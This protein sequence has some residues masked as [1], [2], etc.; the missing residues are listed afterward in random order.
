MAR[1]SP[2][3]KLPPEL[4]NHIY[5]YTTVLDE[6]IDITAIREKQ[7]ALLSGCTEIREEA[8]KMFYHHNSFACRLRISHFSDYISKYP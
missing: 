5:R 7:P 2:L 1:V 8:I 3:W 4:R 6:P